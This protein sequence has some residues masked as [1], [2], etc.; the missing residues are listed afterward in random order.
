M[1]G[2]LCGLVDLV[3]Q[4]ESRSTC[5]RGPCNSLGVGSD[6]KLPDGAH[7]FPFLAAA[8]CLGLAPRAPAPVPARPW[9]P[10]GSVPWRA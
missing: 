6:R 5:R 9:L 4:L 8:V 7:I 2:D 10:L 1:P 3:E